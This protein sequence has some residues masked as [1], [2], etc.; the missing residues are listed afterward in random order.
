MAK[1]KQ[2]SLAR[3]VAEQK[4]ANAAINK[5]RSDVKKQEALDALNAKKNNDPH[6]SYH[7]WSAHVKAPLT[8]DE[9]ADFNKTLKSKP[10]V[11]N[12]AMRVSSRAALK[13]ARKKNRDSANSC[14]LKVGLLKYLTTAY[15]MAADSSL[16]VIREYIENPG[17]FTQLNERADYSSDVN[18]HKYHK[19][20]KIEK[21]HHELIKASDLC[22]KFM[23]AVPSV[24]CERDDFRDVTRY[25]HGTPARNILSILSNPFKRGNSG[26]LGAGIYVTPDVAKTW[27][28][29][30]E[31]S[32]SSDSN[33]QRRYILE[34]ECRLGII[35]Y[36]CGAMMKPEDGH[37]VNSAWNL[38]DGTA[39]YAGP[40]T[41]SGLEYREYCIYSHEQ[42]R[43]VA[44]HE[45]VKK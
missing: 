20:Y 11:S 19:S 26:M 23:A 30:G 8:D 29:N 43:L 1:Q 14:S 25:Y 7:S 3:K 38:I 28:Y 44:I 24:D 41:N 9:I 5:N 18:G 2:N 31:Y 13:A 22:A 15:N 45:F 36:N 21:N 10:C 40:D 42:I 17:K 4:V 37:T 16:F 12:T 27:T 32:F 34:V 6:R 33:E 35:K 39:V